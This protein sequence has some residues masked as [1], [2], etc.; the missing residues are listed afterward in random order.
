MT[1]YGTG[2]HAA[3]DKRFRQWC[4]PSRSAFMRAMSWPS[5]NLDVFV[6]HGVADI[7]SDQPPDVINIF[8]NSELRCA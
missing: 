7:V 8:T 3:Y 6:Y 1:G 5:A 2:S 4:G